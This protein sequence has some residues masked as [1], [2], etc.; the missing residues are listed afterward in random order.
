[1]SVLHVI[2]FYFFLPVQR[3]TSLLGHMQREFS[4]GPLDQVTSK[5][6]SIFL[7]ALERTEG[8]R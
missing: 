3:R 7:W 4:E 8:K 5:E 6:Y 2:Y 1:M